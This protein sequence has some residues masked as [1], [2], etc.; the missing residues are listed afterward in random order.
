MRIMKMRRVLLVV[1]VL[2]LLAAAAVGVIWSISAT[3][4]IHFGFP[5]FTSRYEFSTRAGYVMFTHRQTFD[6][7][8]SSKSVFYPIQRVLLAL[9]LIPVMAVLLEIRRRLP[10]PSRGSGLTHAKPDKPLGNVR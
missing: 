7:M 5:L 10:R 3:R 4:T 6:G 8:V 9:L 1:S 2:S